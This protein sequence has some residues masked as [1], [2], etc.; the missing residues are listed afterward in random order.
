M[1][2]LIQIIQTQIGA[3]EVNSVNSR[4][5]YKYLEIDTPYSMWIQRC[6]DKYDFV[7][8]EDFRTYKFVN[9]EIKNNNKNQTDY[10]VTLDMAKELC[11][12][13]DTLKGKE[14]R[15]YFIKVEKQANKPLTITEQI[16]LI[17]QGHQEVS[18][19]L[20]KLEENTRLENW[21]EKSLIDAKNKKVYELSGDDKVM[22]SKL[23]R[24]VWSLFK[25]KFFLPRYNELKASK[26]DDGLY[27][28]NNLTITDMV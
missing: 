17:A 16:S 14:V 9:P 22:I 28:I 25:K 7:E 5:V 15:K 20:T 6:I 18:E 24:K 23:H 3:E 1:N 12:V 26:F 13:S 2:N 8:N 21:Q 11:M 10:I 19:R 4:N 27:F